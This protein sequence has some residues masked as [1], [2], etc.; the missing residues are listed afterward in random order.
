M[1]EPP[2][3]AIEIASPTQAT[4]DLAD[5][6]RQMLAAVVQSCWLVQ[7]PMQAIT[8]YTDRRCAAGV[9]GRPARRPGD[10]HRNRRGRGLRQCVARAR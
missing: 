5:K 7:P 6:I 4:Q 3:V 2:L 9:F 10:R 8:I 1:S